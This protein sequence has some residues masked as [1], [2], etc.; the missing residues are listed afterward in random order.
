MDVAPAFFFGRRIVRR[1]VSDLYGLVLGPS[2]LVTIWSYDHLVCSWDVRIFFEASSP[3]FR[4]FLRYNFELD[5]L[6]GDPLRC[7]QQPLK[8]VYGG[9]KHRTKIRESEFEVCRVLIL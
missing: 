5:N 8:H 3:P 1:V 4:S 9:Y 6:Y 2:L 7:P